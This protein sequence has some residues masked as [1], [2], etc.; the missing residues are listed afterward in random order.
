MPTVRAEDPRM[1]L[2]PSELLKGLVPP[3]Y[4]VDM[5]VLRAKYDA[6][7]AAFQR[8]FPNVVVGLSYK[9]FYVPR[10]L[11]RLHD[12]GAYAEVVSD[13]EYELALRLGVPGSQIIFNGPGK[14][15][16]SI[17]LALDNGS[18]VNLD[19]L[20]EVEHVIA[21]RPRERTAPVRV[22]L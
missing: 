22:G 17:Q 4:L 7:T 3:F 2:V 9:T 5:A 11:R 12:R 15:A 10:A 20:E 14:S 1:S 8:R 18:I 21:G 19:S 13:V 6:L 16:V